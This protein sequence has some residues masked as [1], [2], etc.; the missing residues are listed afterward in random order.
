M[1]PSHRTPAN[2]CRMGA[3]RRMEKVQLPVIPVVAELIR[4]TP[5]TIS[6]GQ[7]VVYY[8]PPPQAAEQL[9]RF[10]AGT[11][12]HKYKP[13]HGIAPLLEILERKLEAENGIRVDGE[14]ALVVTAG[15]NLAFMNAVLAI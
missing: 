14:N 15:G 6:L 8:G 3:P 9:A 13:V 12:N 1:H 7:G 11:D 4:Q 2:E 10:W 5:G